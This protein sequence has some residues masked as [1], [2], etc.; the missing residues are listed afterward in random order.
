MHP[1]GEWL[2]QDFDRLLELLPVFPPANIPS[3][4]KDA[5]C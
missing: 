2:E 4:V 1:S 5:R 3:A